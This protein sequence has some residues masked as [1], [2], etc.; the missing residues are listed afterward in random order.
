MKLTNYLQPVCRSQEFVDVY[1]DCPARLHGLVLNLL[2]TGKTLP[3]MLI[4][5][6]L[7]D[8]VSN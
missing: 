4:P 7:R 1:I 3:F 8:V 6:R 2:S 5:T